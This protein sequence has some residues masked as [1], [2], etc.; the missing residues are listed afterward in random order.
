MSA[1]IEDTVCILLGM[2]SDCQLLHSIYDDNIIEI[3]QIDNML[4]RLNSPE[5]IR[6]EQ[7][8]ILDELLMYDNIIK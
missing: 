2:L 7:N 1:I 5:E 3:V 4:I 6:Q 8:W